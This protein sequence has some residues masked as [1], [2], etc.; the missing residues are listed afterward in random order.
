[1]MLLRVYS[2]PSLQI[3]KPMLAMS[4]LPQSSSVGSDIL[5]NSCIASRLNIDDHVTS[6]NHKHHPCTSGHMLVAPSLYQECTN[7]NMQKC[8]W[9]VTGYD[10]TKQTA[11]CTCKVSCVY[12]VSYTLD[13][14]KA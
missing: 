8:M 5:Q 9:L 3:T 12:S 4:F 6:D 11:S 2:A 14:M 7:Q 10:K 1:M 13:I